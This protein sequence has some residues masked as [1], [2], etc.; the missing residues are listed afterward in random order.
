MQT[1]EIDT[2]KVRGYRKRIREIK[3]NTKGFKPKK[4]IL[5]INKNK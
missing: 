3:E 2:N 4:D 5:T 1:L